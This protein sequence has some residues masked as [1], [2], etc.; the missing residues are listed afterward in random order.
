METIALHFH[1]PLSFMPGERSLFHSPFATATG[2][3]L[4][5]IRS[6]TDGFYYIH[7]VG[8]AVSFAARQ[9][10]HLIQVLGMNYE[11][12]DVSAARR[13]ERK[14]VWRGL[15]R[16][17]T[18]DGPGEAL[19]LYAS[20]ARRVSEYVAAID[21]FVAE[22]TV[23]TNLRRHLEGSIGWN[24]R[25]NHP[26]K[27]ALYADDNHIGTGAQLGWRLRITADALIAGLDEELEI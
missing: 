26:D 20:N 27:K 13:G 22:T 2:I 25:K 12:L 6:E 18:S 8:E 11:T 3:Y 1:G 5:T 14:H 21:V 17:R 9:R 23:E 7:Y 4:W 15:W 19:G 24:L 10:E 16:A